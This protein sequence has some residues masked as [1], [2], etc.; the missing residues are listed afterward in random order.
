MWLVLDVDGTLAPIHKDPES[1]RLSARVRGALEKLRHRGVGLIVLSGRPASFLRKILPRWMPF[2]SEHGARRL[3]PSGRRFLVRVRRDLE[4]LC[5]AWPGAV[6][7]VKSSALAVHYRNVPKSRQAAFVATL[8]AGFRKWGVRV[9][10]GR[11]VFELLFATGSKKAEVQKL[12][13]R[14]PNAF[15]VAFGD[16]VTDERVFAAVSR[17]GG[18]S[19]RVGNQRQPTCAQFFVPT[20]GAVHALLERWASVGLNQ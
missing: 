14:Y 19:I 1:V 5:F 13:R 16:D 11:K 6:L 4:V 8:R 9:L 18:A 3:S 17:A 12:L 10:E 2:V 20:V 7:E 15:F